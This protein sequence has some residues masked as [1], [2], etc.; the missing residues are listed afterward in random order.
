KSNYNLNKSHPE[1]Y[2]TSDNKHFDKIMNVND[3]K[4]SSKEIKK[5]E[6]KDSYYKS[7]DFE[8]FDKLKK[9]LIFNDNKSISNKN[10][11]VKTITN[12]TDNDK[13]EF[14]QI[15]KLSSNKKNYKMKKID[16]KFDN[17]KIK[18]ID[19]DKLNNKEKNFKNKMGIEK[20]KIIYFD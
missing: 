14:D 1:R 18:I 10:E 15:I 6:S 3:E 17:K 5:S 20:I 12:Y 7:S 11:P 9:F 2:A 4:S 8:N 19:F 16:S 13:S